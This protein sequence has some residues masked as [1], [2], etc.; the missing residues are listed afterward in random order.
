MAL[1]GY[2]NE[3][4]GPDTAN[5][6]MRVIR[7]EAGVAF[8]LYENR[9]VREQTGFLSYE[10]RHCTRTDIVRAFLLYENRLLYQHSLLTIRVCVYAKQVLRTACI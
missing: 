3:A 6:V 9:L 5:V 10:N 4:Q 7:P 8:L 2:V 1:G